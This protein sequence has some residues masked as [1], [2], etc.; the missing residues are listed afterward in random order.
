MALTL[1][2]LTTLYAFN[3]WARVRMLGAVAPL[4]EAAY[5][6]HLGNS[7]GSIHATLAHIVGA[8]EIWLRRWRGETP[9]ALLSADTFRSF[10]DVRAHWE[11]VEA[12]RQQFLAALTDADVLRDVHYTDTRGNQHVTP[13]WQLMQHVVNHSTYHRGQI[14]TMLRQVGATPMPTDLIFFYREQPQDASK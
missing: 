3:T 4:D 5:R 13:L 10:H 9:T 1:Q 12:S 8:E 6:K 2:D 11:G 7:F 14:T